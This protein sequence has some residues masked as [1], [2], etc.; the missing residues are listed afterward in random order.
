MNNREL[1]NILKQYPDDYEILVGH[2]GYD[3]ISVDLDEHY[4][5]IAIDG[6]FSIDT[7]YTQEEIEKHNEALERAD[8]TFEKVNYER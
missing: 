1:I 8:E 5:I 6:F 3:S 4:E 2:Q 7:E